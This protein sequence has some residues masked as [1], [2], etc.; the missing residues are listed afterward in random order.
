MKWGT[1]ILLLLSISLVSA[2]NLFFS[3]YDENV[4]T[5][6]KIFDF[7]E[8]SSE[9][10]KEIVFVMPEMVEDESYVKIIITEEG[11]DPEVVE[12]EAGD[13][14]F[15]INKRDKLKALVIGMREI[16]EMNS[17]FME[18]EEVFSWTFDTP[19][20]YVYT[21]GVVIGKTGEVRVGLSKIYH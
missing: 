12:I 5:A 10:G 7:G 11:F 17:G 3:Y 9:M 13:T 15:W 8:D 6:M 16:T 20:N 14:V 19:G 4:F 2:S 1:I 18:P 21:D